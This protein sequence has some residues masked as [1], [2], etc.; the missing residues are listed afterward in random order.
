VSTISP[1]LH[2]FESF[3]GQELAF[4]ELGEGPTVILVHGLFSH[5]ELNWLRFGHAAA[6]ADAGFRVILPDL[7]AHGLSVSPGKTATWTAGALARDIVALITHLGLADGAYDLGGYSL[8]AR[9]TVRAIEAGARPARAVIGGMG[10]EGMTG[11]SG[12]GAFFRGA[13]DA[14][15]LA[16]PGALTP[17][18]RYALAFART[19]GVDLA[20]ARLLLDDFT[21]IA[22]NQL[23]AILTMPT[24]V[25]CG[26]DDHENGSAPALAALLPT[27]TLSLIE[28]N[29]ATAVTRPGLGAAIAD[30]LRH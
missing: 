18:A 5:G 10:L 29:H 26:A 23:A 3:D 8:G 9:T 20:A 15:A 25:V 22:P 16:T 24:L 19:N 27:A 28:G 14:G 30:F 7:R 21:D 13:I 6:V 17:D 2:R 1:A 11:G 12:R 4:R